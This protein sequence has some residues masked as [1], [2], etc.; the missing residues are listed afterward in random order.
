MF[1]APS[2]K[3][4]YNL[5]A[6]GLNCDWF[7]CK[8]ACAV[9]CV[10]LVPK[11]AS[12]VKLSRGQSPNIFVWN[13]WVLWKLRVRYSIFVNIPISYILSSLS[14]HIILF[15]FPNVFGLTFSNLPPHPSQDLTNEY[16]THINLN[17][18][19]TLLINH[20]FSTFF[21][22]IFLLVRP[23]LSK[24]STKIMRLRTTAIWTVWSGWPSL[25]CLHSLWP[26]PFVTGWL[27]LATQWSDNSSCSIA[28]RFKGT[29]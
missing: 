16:L 9:G 26:S 17:P 1:F 29:P 20:F 5:H 8:F 19:T 28:L 7:V 27:A 2:P 24:H 15:L 18:M 13:Y 21:F 23:L 4:K 12:K 22:V 3:F 14:Q 25:G 10:Q 11:H 6:A